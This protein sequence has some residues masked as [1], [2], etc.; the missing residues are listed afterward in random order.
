MILILFP[1]AVENPFPVRLSEA[2]PLRFGKVNLMLTGKGKRGVMN[3]ASE[4]KKNHRDISAVVEA[5]GAAAV[6]NA[7]VG[8]IY[9]PTDFISPKGR[10]VGKSRSLPGLESAAV[11]GMASLFRG[12]AKK[13]LFSSTDLPLLYSMESLS[14][15]ALCSK[16]RLPFYSLR[17]VTDEGR[18]DI[19]S[20]Y[21]KQLE[22]HRSEMRLLLTKAIKEIADSG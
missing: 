12:E 17:L 9:N 13:E 16:Y 8:G 3:F 18:G 10:V 5:G 11:T 19:K 7:R 4:I 1:L 15:F 2:V 20:F 21:I 14:F 22:K 6:N